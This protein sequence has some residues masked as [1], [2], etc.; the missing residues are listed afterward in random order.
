MGPK[1][2][3][4]PQQQQQQQQPAKKQRVSTTTSS[5]SSIKKPANEIAA[6]AAPPT[7]GRG[8]SATAEEPAAAAAAP[9]VRMPEISMEELRNAAGEYFAANF[10]YSRQK[11]SD[12][13]LLVARDLLI[14]I[15]ETLLRTS[16]DPNPSLSDGVV[17]T[18]LSADTL[19]AGILGCTP[20]LK[21]IIYVCA[22]T[23]PK[24]D[25]LNPADDPFVL[26]DVVSSLLQ[27]LNPSYPLDLCPEFVRPLH[28]RAS[29]LVDGVAATATSAA[30]PADLKQLLDILWNKESAYQKNRAS[31][32]DIGRY[33]AYLVEKIPEIFTITLANE[34]RN[35]LQPAVIEAISPAAEETTTVTQQQQ[36]QQPLQQQ[37][38][39]L[40]AAVATTLPTIEEEQEQ[41]Q[42][43]Q[44]TLPLQESADQPPLRLPTAEELGLPP[45]P[46][47]QQ[48]LLLDEHQQTSEN[49]SNAALQ[50]L[51]AAAAAAVPVATVA[52]AICDFEIFSECSRFRLTGEGDRIS[53]TDVKNKTLMV[54]APIGQFT[55]LINLINH[56]PV[57]GL[58]ADSRAG[59]ILRTLC[60]DA[61]RCARI[62][63]LL[64]HLSSML[65]N[66]ITWHGDSAPNESF[67]DFGAYA[68]CCLSAALGV[69]SDDICLFFSHL[70]GVAATAGV[71]ASNLRATVFDLF[72]SNTD[73]F[74]SV[75]AWV[76]CPLLVAM[77]LLPRVVAETGPVL[78]GTTHPSVTFD[79]VAIFMMV[80]IDSS[81]LSHPDGT[82][83][84]PLIYTLVDMLLRIGVSPSVMMWLFRLQPLPA[85]DL[86]CD[87][88][89][90]NPLSVLDNMSDF[91]IEAWRTGVDNGIDKAIAVMTL[92][93]ARNSCR[94]CPSANIRAAYS[95]FGPD[96]AYAAYT[97]DAFFARVMLGRTVPATPALA[98]HVN[99]INSRDMKQFEVLLPTFTGKDGF[100]KPMSMWK[101]TG[102]R[103]RNREDDDDTRSV[104]S[105]ATAVSSRSR[106][107]RGNK[108]KDKTYQP[109][110]YKRSKESKQR[111][112][113]GRVSSAAA[114][115]VAAAAAADDDDD[116]DDDEG[117]AVG[118]DEESRA[119]IDPVMIATMQQQMQEMMK[120]LARLNRK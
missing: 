46:E 51:A 111:G 35:F 32:S 103:G 36:Q 48:Q 23:C 89:E 50:G 71:F 42:Q 109:S 33:F 41:Q 59:L 20:G 83:T 62:L 22:S 2:K 27:F 93:S 81:L 90:E 120:Q 54:T 39:I 99:A 24:D 63:S 79:F 84:T 77:L 38:P 110:G 70:R 9:L 53:L 67:S 85:L 92:L 104:A 86:L 4:A 75:S 64:A 105:G 11:H 45:I 115:A 1:R 34:I 44:P 91:A 65:V 8:R 37:E 58:D 101:S 31:T 112:P 16:L 56:L 49:E 95:A 13:I 117:G 116:D 21:Y 57:G 113:G 7:R 88:A 106:S 30:V 55:D 76:V 6:A 82:V 118:E 47:P 29:E 3:D 102:G 5:S 18:D 97:A 96:S 74:V 60:G 78:S 72:S 68:S 15:L 73:K 19:L 108:S 66:P 107:Y 61:P 52:V 14:V 100:L 12:N 69:S 43:Q 98:D 87:L 26:T 17:A 119:A 80:T 40:A 114:A 10:N 28:L 94:K 25:Y